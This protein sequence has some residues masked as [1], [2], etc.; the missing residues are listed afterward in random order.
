MKYLITGGAG[1]IGS[2]LL[3]ALARNADYVVVVDDL[4]SGSIDNISKWL[5]SN[6]ITFLKQDLSKTEISPKFLQ[7]C[8][9]V[10]HL[11]ANPEVRIGST[12]PDVHFRQNVLTTFNVLESVRK[13]AAVKKFIFASSSTVYGEAK[14]IPTPEEYSPMIPISVYGASKLACESL[15]SAYANTYGFQA[16]IA[17]LANVVG[18]RSRHGVVYD[19]IKKLRENPRRL[20][21][22]GDGTQSKS[23]IH[24][25][26]C[27]DA[28]LLLLEKAMEKVSIFNVG[29]E[30]KVDVKTI[31]RIVIEEMGLHDVELYFTGGIDGGR[32]WIGDVK[33]M[34]LDISKIKKL[35]WIPRFTSYESIKMAVRDLLKE[36]P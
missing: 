20:E 24:I 22:L 15:I 12:S 16:I 28:L 18:S 36:F 6:N 17:R 35:G 21:I 27:I 9:V 33:T 5:S 4:S 26:D 7:D 31:A 8:E 14:Q 10:F 1:F 23:Y 2:H 34:Q 29:S 13:A 25:S 11:A 19:F 32:G 3:D 30:D